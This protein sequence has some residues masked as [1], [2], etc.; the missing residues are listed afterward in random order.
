M[1]ND[2]ERD[3]ECAKAGLLGHSICLCKGEV[4]ITDDRRGISP[5]MAFISEDKDLEGY[6]VAD[7]IVGKAAAMLF[8]KAGIKNVFGKVM[9]KAG[10]DYLDRHGIPCS[11]DE[12]T[13]KIINRAGTDICPMEKTVTELEDAEEAYIEL[14]KKLTFSSKN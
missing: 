2:L 3:M 13:D 5:M 10:K 4:I 7:L 8:V 6:S 12:L 9:S 14:Q 1:V 11:Y